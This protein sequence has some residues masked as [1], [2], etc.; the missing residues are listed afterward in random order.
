MKICLFGAG[1]KNIN[2]DYIDVGYHLG[3][4]IAKN[5][6]SLVFGGGNDG[7]MVCSDAS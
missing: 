5:N 6:H 1:S 7:M 2:Q 3:E 4:Q